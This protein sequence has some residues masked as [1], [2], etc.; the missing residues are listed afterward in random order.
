MCCKR[1]AQST[2]SQ[3]YTFASPSTAAGVVV[4]RA[5]NGRELW[6]TK[7]GMMLKQVQEGSSHLMIPIDPNDSTAIVGPNEAGGTIGLS[8]CSS[9]SRVSL[10]PACHKCADRILL[11][12]EYS[13][14]VTFPPKAIRV[15]RTSHPSGTAR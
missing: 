1:L 4:G 8:R 7:D 6:R 14:R 3:D 9:K 13:G 11:H 10:Y 2:R 15:Q 12:T 5:A